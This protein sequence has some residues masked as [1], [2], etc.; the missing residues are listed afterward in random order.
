MIFAKFHRQ[1]GEVILAACDA[2]VAGKCLAD[3]EMRL[4]TAGEFFDGEEVTEAEF[5]GMLAQATSA[6]L[7]GKNVVR[8]AVEEG[9]VHPDA[10][11]DVCGV[12]FAMFFCMR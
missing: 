9:C 2:D 8:I 10:C 4:D 5:R 3:G 6:N 1:G 7:V 12:P 11:I